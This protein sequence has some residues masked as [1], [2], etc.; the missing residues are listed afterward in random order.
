MSAYYEGSESENSDQQSDPEESEV[1]KGEFELVQNEQGFS[2]AVEAVCISF[3]ND[4]L[5]YSKLWDEHFTHLDTVLGIL[6][7]ESLYAKESK[8]ELGMT[9]LLYLGHIIS[10]D[11]VRMDPEKIRAIIEWPTPENLTQ[12]RGFL[13]LCGFYHR[14]VNG[15]SRHAAPL[16]NLMKKGA[17]IWTP[18]A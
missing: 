18:E 10:V 15:Y 9:K 17:F 6:N 8:C 4:I 14:F 3:F 1:E 11:G 2:G 16:T 12:L 13:S 5:A 7:N